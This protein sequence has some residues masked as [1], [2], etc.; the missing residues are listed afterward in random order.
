[1]VAAGGGGVCDAGGCAAGGLV[2]LGD[3][4]EPLA[5]VGAADDEGGAA[6][7]EELVTGAVVPGFGAE[8]G[9]DGRDACAVEVGV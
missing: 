2:E 5:V 8:D 4:A 9:V 1:M 6:G 7:A 3:E